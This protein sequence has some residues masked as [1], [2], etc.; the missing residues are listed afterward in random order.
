MRAG[1]VMMIRRATLALVPLALALLAPTAHAEV[2][3]KAETGFVIRSG[4][5]VEA[6][7]DAAW[8]TLVDPSQWWSPDHT[9]SSDAANLSLDPRVEGCF[10]ELLPSRESPNAAP[11]GHV[12]HMRVIFIDRGRMLRLSGALGPLQSE[13]VTGTLT[14]NLKPRDGGGSRILWEY[15]VGGYMRYKTDEIAPAVDKVIGEQ[16]AR[17]AA[18]LGPVAAPS[19]VPPQAAPD[20]LPP[21]A[22]PTELP[23]ADPRKPV[24]IGR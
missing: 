3:Q 13:A 6:S 17:L 1:D 8:R 4:A 16:L 7:P 2:H 21:P 19:A 5:D 18:K 20:P 23:P 12:E 9:Y 24:M 11:R 10:C 15:V 22:A 14:M